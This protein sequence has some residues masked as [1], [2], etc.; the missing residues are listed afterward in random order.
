MGS[1]T[2]VSYE[3]HCK[4]RA[5]IHTLVSSFQIGE[6]V[7]AVFIKFEKRIAT[8]LYNFKMHNQLS[9]LNLTVDDNKWSIKID[10]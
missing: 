6:E 7:K 8:L 10:T 3:M 4:H 1:I 9:A 5:T 2:P